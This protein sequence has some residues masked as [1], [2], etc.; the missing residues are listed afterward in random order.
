M[1]VGGPGPD[2]RTGMVAL[3]QRILAEAAV[4]SLDGD[5]G[6][7]VVDLPS[8]FDPGTDSSQF[9]RGLENSFVDVVPATVDRTGEA[10]VVDRVAYPTR[11]VVRELDQANFTAAQRMVE[12][13]VPARRRTRA[14]RHDRRAGAHRGAAA[15]CPTSSAT[16]R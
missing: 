15:R 3:R 5:T 1:A 7:L 10:P 4:R 9:F 6:N 2:E 13:G 12:A 16:T 11:Q 14:Q 8:D